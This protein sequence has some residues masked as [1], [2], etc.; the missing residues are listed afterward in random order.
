MTGLILA[1]GAGRRVEGRDKGLVHWQGKP[2]VEHIIERLKPQ[3]D[4]III[5]CNR[6]SDVYQQ[7]APVVAG[8]SRSNYQG[9]LAGIEAAS[10]SITSDRVL[11]VPCDMPLLPFDLAQ[12]LAEVIEASGGTAG[13]CYAHDGARAQ[14]LCALIDRARLS[15]VT[16]FL[17]GGQRAVREWYAEGNALSADFSDQQIA[18]QNFNELD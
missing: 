12:K 4:K 5:S 15:S 8:D 10:A 16:Q 18:F 2:L 6:N 3:V 13:I 17:D 14:Y 1:G 7:Y 9:P 11:V